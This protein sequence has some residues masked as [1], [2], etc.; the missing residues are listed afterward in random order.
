[1]FSRVTKRLSYKVY[2]E[3]LFRE[4]LEEQQIITAK[5]EALYQNDSEVAD[6]SQMD[7]E[8]ALALARERAK[9]NVRKAGRPTSKST[10]EIGYGEGRCSR[11]V[12]IVWW[13]TLYSRTSCHG[14]LS[15][16]F[17]LKKVSM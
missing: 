10:I 15:V 13:P 1:M 14:K 11:E 2:D 8:D 3:Q 12:E 16:R 7:V 5:V 17:Y 6:I 9:K 4:L